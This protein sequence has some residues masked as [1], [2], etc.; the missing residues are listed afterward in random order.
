MGVPPKARTRS[1]LDIV[2]THVVILKS[3]VDRIRLHKSDT[4]PPINARKD[5]VEQFRLRLL[6]TE[7]TDS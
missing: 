1:F 3:N 6:K 5:F 4:A 7:Q 2:G